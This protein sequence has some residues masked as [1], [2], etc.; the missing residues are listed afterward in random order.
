MSNKFDESKMVVLARKEVGNGLTVEVYRYAD[1][2]PSVR[3]L[4]GGFKL[5][6]FR[7]ADVPGIT[8]AMTEAVHDLRVGA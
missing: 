4:K 7:A 5:T 6:N 1:H 2:E 3:V 8:A